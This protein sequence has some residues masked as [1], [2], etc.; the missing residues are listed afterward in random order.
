MKQQFSKSRYFT[1]PR[2][3]SGNFKTIMGK[4]RQYSFTLFLVVGVLFFFGCSQTRKPTGTAYWSISDTDSIEVKIPFVV[5]G[6]GNVHQLTVDEY[7]FE[8]SHWLYFSKFRQN[9]TA[10]SLVLAHERGETSDPWIQSNLKGNII[11]HD[12]LLTINFQL[13]IYNEAEEITAWEAYDFNGV[14]D[15][16]KIG[17]QHERR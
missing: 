14:Y 7:E 9:I 13:P 1:N 2:S 16:K 8:Q 11:I 4:S 15:L 3:V 17:Q 6:R 5:K 10:D 12:S